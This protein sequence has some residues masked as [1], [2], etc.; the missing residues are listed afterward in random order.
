[1]FMNAESRITKVTDNIVL[2]ILVV[3]SL[4]RFLA[5]S[6]S[7]PVNSLLHTLLHRVP[8]IHRFRTFSIF[9]L[10]SLA[11]WLPRSGP[12]TLRLSR[13][14]SLT[15][16]APLFDHSSCKLDM[17]FVCTFNL[18]LSLTTQILSREF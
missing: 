14:F 1:M 10:S 5:S 12:P 7:R 2:S 18:K 9:V 17:C 3:S 13:T 8:S 6:R 11:P 16:L 15:A 4:P